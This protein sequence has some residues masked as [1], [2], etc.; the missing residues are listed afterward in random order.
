MTDSNIGQEEFTSGIIERIPNI[1]G[2]T[3]NIPKNPQKCKKYY[4]DGRC[5]L[6]G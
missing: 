4:S 1:G 6:R 2:G 3:P 5:L